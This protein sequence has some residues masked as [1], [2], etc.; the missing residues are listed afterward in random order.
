MEPKY[1]YEGEIGKP[2]G[3]TPILAIFLGALHPSAPAGD[4]PDE[5]V[6]VTAAEMWEVEMTRR[7]SEPS[8]NDEWEHHVKI[9]SPGSI[10][11]TRPCDT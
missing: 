8:D 6:L 11:V 2:W 5:L 4:S 1:S 3:G 10:M 7:L 9:L